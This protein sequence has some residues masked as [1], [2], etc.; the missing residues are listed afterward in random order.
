VFNC[1]L[2]VRP[3]N[4]QDDQK[5]RKLIET[6]YTKDKIL[7]DF[8]RANMANTCGNQSGLYSF[9]ALAGPAQQSHIIGL[10]ILSDYERVEHYQINYNIDNFI[11]ADL[12]EPCE[13]AYVHH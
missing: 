1:R 4:E 10:I 5:V 6:L 9:V 13:C 8:V 3:G 7:N 2:R 11:Y 12:H